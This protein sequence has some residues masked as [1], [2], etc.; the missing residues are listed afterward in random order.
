MV[1]GVAE[2]R[3]LDQAPGG[4]MP[5]IC[6]CIV[7]NRRGLPQAL[8]EPHFIF[9]SGEIHTP[10][11]LNRISYLFPGRVPARAGRLRRSQLA[12]VSSLSCYGR[13]DTSQVLPFLQW[14]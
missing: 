14:Y 1:Y 9:I 13:P 6:C 3:A 2:G 7:F 8:F 12:V 4:I 10:K 11:H 5:V